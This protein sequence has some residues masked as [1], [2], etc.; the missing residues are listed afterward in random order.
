MKLYKKAAS[1]EKMVYYGIAAVILVGIF[2]LFYYEVFTNA[3][4]KVRVPEKVT[5]S[6][7]AERFINSPDCFTYQDLD[8][9]IFYDG[10][11]DWN[12]LTNYNL[13]RCY[14]VGDSYPQN[15]VVY[16]PAFRLRFSIPSLDLE[17]VI[18]TTNYD[19][20]KAYASRITRSVRIYHNDQ[21]RIGELSV[22][23]QKHVR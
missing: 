5:T 16:V 11:I 23:V 8:S 9:G 17:K 4:L 19:D 1:A 2:Y 18:D 20:N 13:E 21:L 22:E 15:V 7:F 6:V 10:I 14:S 12:K 3:N